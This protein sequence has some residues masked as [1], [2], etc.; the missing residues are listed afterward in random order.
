MILY[1]SEQVCSSNKILYAIL[2]YKHKNQYLNKVTKNPYQYLIETQRN[3]LIQLLQK[4]EDVSDGTLSTWK[5][6]S[7]DF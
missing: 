3:E 2:D 4:S 7:V 5:T 6:D 1:E